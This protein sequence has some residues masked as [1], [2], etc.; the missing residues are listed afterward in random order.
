[1]GHV[2]GEIGMGRRSEVDPSGPRVPCYD[3][4]WTLG[5]SNRAS[6]PPKSWPCDNVC[7][8]NNVCDMNYIYI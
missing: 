6:E 1:M 4:I 2:A 7:N 5:S 3:H 8:L